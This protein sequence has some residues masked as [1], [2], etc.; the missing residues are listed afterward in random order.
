MRSSDRH[1]VAVRES[2]ELTATHDGVV[3]TTVDTAPPATATPAI[4]HERTTA[5]RAALPA[6]ARFAGPVIA[7]VMLTLLPLFSSRFTVS[8][9]T[10]VLAFAVLALSLHLLMGWTG[11]ISL[12]QAGYFGVGAYAAGL[13]AVHHNASAPVMLLMGAV[14]GAVA[15]AATG[16]L[17]VRSHGGYLLMITIAI[18]ELLSHA[19]NSWHGLTNGDDGL[20]AI[21]FT[22]LGGSVLRETDHIYWYTLVVAAIC[23]LAMFLIGRSPFGRT[24]RGTRDNE[25][26]MRSLGYSTYVYKSVAFTIAGAIAGVAGSLWV[27]YAQFVSPRD[28]TLKQSS[29]VLVAVAVGGTFRLWGAFVGAAIVIV[30]Q[31]HLPSFLEGKYSLVL[32]LLLIVIVYVLPG[33][34]SALPQRIGRMWRNAR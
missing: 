29:M 13:M 1:P 25:P 16:W 19:A 11:I 6:A 17:L 5:R 24:L 18:G 8:T 27:T 32:G 14:S 28:L 23:T 20:A 30:T 22:E 2:V 26:R 4:E 9:A 31:N 21:P 15:A 33:G 3:G 12:G 7:A 34:F 10:Q